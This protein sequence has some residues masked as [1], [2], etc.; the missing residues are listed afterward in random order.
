MHNEAN[1]FIFSISLQII[2]RI[3]YAAYCSS[4]LSL[5]LFAPFRLLSGTRPATLIGRKRIEE[6]IA[7]ARQIATSS[8]QVCAALGAPRG[9][10]ET[11]IPVSKKFRS[12]S[13]DHRKREKF[14]SRFSIYEIG[15]REIT[16][17]EGDRS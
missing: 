13:D 8:T 5:A 7:L 6:K 16:S 2:F 10:Q 14:P 3:K 12:N 11:Y 17:A 15:S 1:R 4:H 9:K